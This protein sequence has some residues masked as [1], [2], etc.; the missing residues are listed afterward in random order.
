[1]SGGED[2][3]GRSCVKL[4]C[5]S[6]GA[7]GWG[8]YVLIGFCEI[9]VDASW[10]VAWRF[11]QAACKGGAWCLLWSDI[12][13]AVET[14]SYAMQIASSRGW[15]FSMWSYWVFGRDVGRI[16]FASAVMKS[17]GEEV[18]MKC[19]SAC[20]L[21]LCW[22]LNFFYLGWGWIDCGFCAGFLCAC[23]CG[24]AGWKTT[25]DTQVAFRQSGV[26]RDLLDSFSVWSI[27]GTCW[28]R[29]YNHMLKALCFSL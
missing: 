22:R 6:Y 14:A 7:W 16:G 17:M 3:A 27:L 28:G 11:V 2:G 26:D 1:M 20:G 25:W 21:W 18:L 4:Q 19:D 10:C 8:E 29:K 5:E 13:Y 24:V 12:G 23:F 15:G 9:R